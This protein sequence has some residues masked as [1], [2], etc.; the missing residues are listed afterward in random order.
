M[1]LFLCL[2]NYSFLCS[3]YL[4]PTN[5]FALPPWTSIPSEWGGGGGEGGLVKEEGR[6]V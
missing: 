5:T 1:Q 4:L 6:E 2:I 3:F